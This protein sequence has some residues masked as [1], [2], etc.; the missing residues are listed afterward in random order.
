MSHSWGQFLFL[1]S[2]GL[3][4][5]SWIS[6]TVTVSRWAQ[7][8]GF[9]FQGKLNFTRSSHSREPG[10]C[11]RG[12]GGRGLVVSP[13][14]SV[15]EGRGAA[16][17]FGSALRSEHAGL[18][19]GDP[20]RRGAGEAV[21]QPPPAPSARAAPS[22]LLPEENASGPWERG[23]L[24]LSRA[25]WVQASSPGPQPD[26]V[27]LLGARPGVTAQGSGVVNAGGAPEPPHP[28]APASQA[29]SS[30]SCFPGKVPVFAPH[31]PC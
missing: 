12:S 17:G 9:G 1:V 24:A 27:A 6:V 4:G 28:P 11:P 10:V 15:C 13:E 21:G 23:R 7:R 26:R 19:P 2:D 5:S 18:V 8:L 16:A 31:R 20:G 25:C 30:L 3:S 14:D 29:G 22:P